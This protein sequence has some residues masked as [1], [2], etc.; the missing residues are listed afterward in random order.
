MAQVTYIDPIATLKGRLGKRSQGR[1]DVHRQKTYGYD[2]NGNPIVGPNESYIYHIHEG[3]WSEGAV[4]NRDLFRQAQNQAKQEL[5]DPV[6]AAQWQQAFEH[7][8]NHPQNTPASPQSNPTRKP[9]VTLK[10]F[11][12]AQIHKRLK[13]NL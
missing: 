9:Y 2:S 11:V 6:L 7:Q 8:L 5:A 1:V 13:E 4:K 10:G 12:V 3:E